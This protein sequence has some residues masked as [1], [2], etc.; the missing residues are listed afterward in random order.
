MQ[1]PFLRPLHSTTAKPSAAKQRGLLLIEVLI[2]L[3]LF[4]VGILGLVKAMT[5]SQVAQTDAQ[6]RSDAAKHATDIVQAI[7]MAAPRGA[8]K[9]S[10]ATSLA[11]FNHQPVDGASA[12]TFSGTV[13]TRPEVVAWVNQVR[14]GSNRLPGALD[15][16]Q[17]ISIDTTAA[18]R[19]KVVVVLCWK[20]PTD[21]VARRHIYTAYVN[22]NF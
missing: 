17:Q 18:G 5:V 20:G 14:T 3:L 6:F 10:F 12:C 22:E 11:D 7:W 2:A 13:S 9:A 4:A 21:T 19:N 1:T 15:T 16:M 8:T